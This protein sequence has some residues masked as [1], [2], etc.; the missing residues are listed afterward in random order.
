MEVGELEEPMVEIMV[1]KP[2][3]MTAYVVGVQEEQENA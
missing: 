1:Q 2:A 3:K